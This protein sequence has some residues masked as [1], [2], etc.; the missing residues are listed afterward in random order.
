MAFIKEYSLTEMS[1]LYDFK[2]KKTKDSLESADQKE[3]LQFLENQL[4]D[5]TLRYY[6]S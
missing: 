1:S 3:V 5:Y 6:K 4:E 2:K